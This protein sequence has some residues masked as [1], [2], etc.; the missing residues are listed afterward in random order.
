MADL[1]AQ[2]PSCA[3]LIDV[4]DIVKGPADPDAPNPV[5]A[6]ARPSE[7]K[8]A[9]ESLI[10]KIESEI[11]A[12]IEKALPAAVDAFIASKA[13]TA[14]DKDENEQPTEGPAS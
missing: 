3:H 4:T 11:V 10:E 8:A 12:G 7:L 6:G 9:H 2:C 1:K 5:L 14:A 13:E